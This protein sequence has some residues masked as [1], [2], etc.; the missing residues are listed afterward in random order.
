[1]F[2][3]KFRLIFQ[4]KLNYHVMQNTSLTVFAYVLVLAKHYRAM[5]FK[6][7]CST[8]FSTIHILAIEQHRDKAR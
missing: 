7:K 4:A 5:N 3:L 8:K 6:E 2:S 1:M